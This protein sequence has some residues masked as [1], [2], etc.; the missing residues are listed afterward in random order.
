[1]FSFY[2]RRTQGKNSKQKL[3]KIVIE[4][5][6]YAAYRFMQDTARLA[7]DGTY[8]KPVANSADSIANTGMDSAQYVLD[9]LSRCPPR[10]TL[11]P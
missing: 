8:A 7:V 2:T 1:M 3:Y 4:T 11:V 6:E 10:I 9:K 5:D